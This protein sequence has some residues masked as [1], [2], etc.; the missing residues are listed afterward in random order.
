MKIQVFN[1]LGFTSPVTIRG[2]TLISTL[3][4]KK[5]SDDHWDERVDEESNKAWTLLKQDLEGLS[6]IEFPRYS[7]S[8]GGQAD[9]YLFSDASKLA[10]GF[11]AYAVQNGKSGFICSRTKVAPVIKKSL[12]TLELLGVFLALKNL[13][14]MLKT[15]KKVNIKN[16]YLATDSPS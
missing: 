11:V 12:P 1:P 6:N 8:E 3:W 16:V 10:Y 7:L 4:Q 2:K 5:Q 14:S 15:F 9:L 13:F